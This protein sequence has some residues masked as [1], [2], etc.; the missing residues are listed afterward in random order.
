MRVLLLGATGTAGRRASAEFVRSDQTSE[1]T[2]AARTRRKVESFASL[3][4]GRSNNV[5][6]VSIDATN[7]PAMAQAAAEHDVV[8]SCAGPSN[9]LERIAVQACVEA[10]TPYVSLCDDHE[11]ASA[12]FELDDRARKAGV[13]VVTGCGLSPGITNLLVAFAAEGLDGVEEIEIAVAYSLSDA[14][15]NSLLTQLTY[16]LGDTNAPYVSEYRAASGRAGELPRPI[17]FP[18]PVGWVETV[19]CG[20]PEAITALRVYS[21]L[22]A[23]RFRAGTTERAVMDALRASIALRSKRAGRPTEGWL[24]LTRATVPLLRA[25]P[26]RSASWS[27]ARVDVWGTREGRPESAA[28]GVVDHIVNLVSLPLVHAAIEIGSGHVTRPGVNGIE[29]VFQPKPFLG[30]LAGRGLRAARLTPEIL[31]MR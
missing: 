4:G 12:A 13:T 5:H 26:P 22:R 2:L 7:S 3:L 30:W 9:G 23:M 11:A 21:D 25:L 29:E 19:T 27:A 16:G 8:A 1:V 15:S 17:Y 6:G 24:R 28:L 10:G 14:T 18:E 20:H 31:E